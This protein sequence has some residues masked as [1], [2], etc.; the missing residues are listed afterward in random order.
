MRR[1]HCPF[2][3]RADERCAQHLSLQKLDSAFDYCFGRY[4]ACAVYFELLLRRRVRLSQPPAGGGRVK[5]S[6]RGTQP[7]IKPAASVSVVPGLGAG[8]G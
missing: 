6:I 4:T 1:H 2:L 5:L 3:N 7:G 8:P